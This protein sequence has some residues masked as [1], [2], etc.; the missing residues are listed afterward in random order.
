MSSKHFLAIVCAVLTAMGARA[1]SPE[2]LQMVDSSAVATAA[3]QLDRAEFFLQSAMQ[4]EPSNPGNIMLLSNLGIIQFRNGK[5][6]K[7]LVTLGRAHAMAP[8]A[9]V[10]LDNRAGVLAAMGRDQEAMAD[11]ACI[12]EIDSLHAPA[13]FSHAMLAM[14]QGDI[15]TAA[16]ELE[17]LNGV[18][19]ADRNTLMGMASLRMAQT[20]FSDAI[21]FLDRLI[22]NYGAEATPSEAETTANYYYSRAYCRM[23]NEQLSECA[24]DINKAIALDP[25]NPDSYELRAALHRMSYRNT[26]AEADS[27]KAKELRQ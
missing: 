23:L 9:V 16:R 12:L 14:R 20:R 2:Y 11:Y 18:R 6:D 7:A 17:R 13:L 4:M 15:A 10:V 25:S 5:P 19:P 26:E 1:Q 22:D 21:P 8:R 3:G 27:K 24:A